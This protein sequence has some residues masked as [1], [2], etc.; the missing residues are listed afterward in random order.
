MR[1]AALRSALSVKAIEKQIVVLNELGVASAKTRDMVSVLQS[2]GLT[3][4][5]LILLADRDG[6][7]ENSARNLPQVTTL[8]ASYVNV[9]DLL[10][11]E[12][13]VLPLESLQVVESIL[14]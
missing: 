8:R 13:V 3:E 14:G 10:S 2:L 4:S 12:H 9:R 7:V 6:A 1:R 5:V 11:H